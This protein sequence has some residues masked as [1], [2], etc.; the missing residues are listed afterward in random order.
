M[1]GRDF[2]SRDQQ[3]S[4]SGEINCMYNNIPMCW[5]SVETS[6]LKGVL[7]D[8]RLR[9]HSWVS[10]ENQQSNALE[11]T[12]CNS[13][14]SFDLHV[15][16]AILWLATLRSRDYRRPQGDDILPQCLGLANLGPIA[17]WSELMYRYYTPNLI[18]W[19]RLWPLTSMTLTN[20]NCFF[21]LNP[22]SPENLSAITIFSRYCPI[23]RNGCTCPVTDPS[24]SLDPIWVTLKRVPAMSFQVVMFL[25]YTNCS[26]YQIYQ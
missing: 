6:S 8:N 18:I 20:R 17:N 10:T 13:N 25:M 12:A 11:F 14:E 24:T 4:A 19:R 7:I 15:H 5:S 23:L 16:V 3:H 2:C 1:F 26:V 22:E 9:V 21:K